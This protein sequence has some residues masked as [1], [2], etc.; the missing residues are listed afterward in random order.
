[1]D[2][3]LEE[4]SATSRSIMDQLRQRQLVPD[5]TTM[6]AYLA[7]FCNCLDQD[8]AEKVFNNFPFEKNPSHFEMMLALYDSLKNDTGTLDLMGPNL[9][10]KNPMIN[11]AAARHGLRTLALT[12]H[13]EKGCDIL[14]YQIGGKVKFEDVKELYHSAFREGNLQVMHFIKSRCLRLSYCQP[15]PYSRIRKRSILLGD[16]LKE[17]YGTKGPKIATDPPSDKFKM[18]HEV[19]Q[20]C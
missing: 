13:L 10:K 11:K 15:N 20:Q 16:I 2:A 17:G 12:G 6:T 18:K 14:H 19:K 3:K 9:K 7:I 8:N 4:I 1:M 5:L